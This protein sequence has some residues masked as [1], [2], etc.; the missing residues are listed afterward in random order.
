M[1]SL[2]EDYLSIL[3]EIHNEVKEVLK[4]DISKLS[5]SN[6]KTLKNLDRQMGIVYK[7]AYRFQ[8]EGKKVNNEDKIFSI[9]EEHTDIISKGIREIVFG[10][11]INLATGTSNLFLYCKVEEG[12]PSDTNLFEEPLVKIDEDYKDVK[13]ETKSV[14]TDGGYTSSANLDFAKSRKLVNI[15]FTKIVGSLKSVAESVEIENRL[16]KWRGGIEGCISNVKRGFN[17]GRVTWK[18]WGMF[19]AKVFWSVIAYNIRV[20]TGH[21]LGTMKTI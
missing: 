8:I 6:Q 14:A 19:N 4:T 7:N 10:H 9:Y 2:F 15:V 11:K 13:K 21:I 12:N 20:L 18:G 16:T 3:K 1:K 5:K 17:L